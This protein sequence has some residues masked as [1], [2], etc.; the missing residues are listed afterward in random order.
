VLSS[1]GHRPQGRTVWSQTPYW[2]PVA[3]QSTK[4]A[5]SVA[6]VCSATVSSAQKSPQQLVSMFVQAQGAAM[7]AV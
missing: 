1:Q 7:G 6:A 2:R 4:V 3:A 5:A